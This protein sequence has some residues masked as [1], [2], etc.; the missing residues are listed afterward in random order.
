MVEPVVD[1]TLLRSMRFTSPVEVSRRT[2]NNA[3]VWAVS[4]ESH[5]SS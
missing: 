2:Q 3:E 1:L 4:D 5:E